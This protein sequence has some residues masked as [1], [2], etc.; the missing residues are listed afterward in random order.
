MAPDLLQSFLVNTGPKDYS[1][2][3]PM[4]FAPRYPDQPPHVKSV[5][6]RFQYTGMEMALDVMS[7]VTI[8]LGAPENYFEPL[9]DRSFTV[10][11][12]NYYPPLTP[13]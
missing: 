13:E 9:F 10:S 7:L 2:H 12:L 3:H 11:C 1:K 8:E 6:Q 5:M 4:L